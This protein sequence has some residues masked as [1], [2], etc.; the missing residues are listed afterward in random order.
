MSPHSRTRVAVGDASRARRVGG[1]GRCEPSD[2]RAWPLASRAEN[3]WR[4][5]RISLRWTIF[6]GGVGWRARSSHSWGMWRL[7]VIAALA[8][9]AARPVVS[10]AQL[11][12]MMPEA[13]DSGPP[14]GGAPS[15]LVVMDLDGSQ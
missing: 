8:G 10:R 2:A 1:R 13:A 15:D 9:C 7:V 12:V 14:G 3:A 11:V 4:G 5:G 6:A